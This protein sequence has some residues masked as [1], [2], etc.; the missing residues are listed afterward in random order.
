[1]PSRQLRTLASRLTP[2]LSV[3]P[4]CFPLWGSAVSMTVIRIGVD[5]RALQGEFALESTMQNQIAANPGILWTPFARVIVSL[6][7]N[8]TRRSWM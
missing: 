4:T 5:R 2:P 7:E 6:A 1:M 8:V 3:P